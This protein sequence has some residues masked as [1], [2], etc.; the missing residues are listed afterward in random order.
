VQENND[1]VSNVDLVPA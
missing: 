1:N